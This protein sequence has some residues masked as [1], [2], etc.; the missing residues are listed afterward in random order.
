MRIPIT[1][2]KAKEI[3]AYAAKI[4][5]LLQAAKTLDDSAIPD[6][7]KN[8]SVW[9]L[10]GTPVRVKNMLNNIGACTLWELVHFDI[11]KCRKYRGGFF[12]SKH[13]MRELLYAIKEAID[14]L[15]APQ[16]DSNKKTGR[17]SGIKPM[18]VEEQ[19][20][21]NVDCTIDTKQKVI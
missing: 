14:L 19:N 20:N 6:S 18:S 10:E 17:M 1:E 5:K 15:R 13:R 11:A 12:A 7:V 21:L 16:I 9:E 8:L 3:E 2:E 4:D